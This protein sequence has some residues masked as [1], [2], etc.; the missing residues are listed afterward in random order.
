MTDDANGRSTAAI[1]IDAGNSKTDMMLIGVDGRVIASAQ[2]GAFRPH[3]VGV[4]PAVDSLAALVQELRSE[5]DVPPDVVL[6]QHV[7]ACLANADLDREV[8]A[9]HRE[10]AS[11][12][13][14]N[15]TTVRNDTFG[16]L[17]AGLD[18][19]DGVA[20][21]C[22]AGI[23]CAGMS[24]DGT[25][26]RFAAVGHIS[27]DWGGGESLWR[28]AMWWAARA[29]DGRGPATALQSA[30]PRNFGFDSMADLI[31][32][33]HLGDIPEA[34]CLQ[35]TPLLFAVSSAGDPV[36]RAVV[37]RQADEIVRLA[38]AAIERLGR[39]GTPIDVVLGGG[40]LTAGHP[41]LMTEIDRLLG[42]AQPHARTHVVLAPPVLGAGL[43]AL[44]QLGVGAGAKAKL[45]AHFSV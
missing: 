23:N 11:R 21:V 3:V 1:A 6:A 7:S 36:A 30:L 24:S 45:R 14:A 41:E 40:V 29:E 17:R 39:A 43:L 25:V 12:G 10:I 16:L 27:G 9:L 15:T 26:V 4:V 44:D 13:W 34:A 37:Q 8:A 22:G 18:E 31:A 2:G 38:V 42:Q 35:M 28:E 33:V 19:P 5:V 20:V 32:G